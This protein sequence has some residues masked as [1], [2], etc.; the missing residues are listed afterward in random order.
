MKAIEKL[1]VVHS[2]KYHKRFFMLEF[3]EPY[4]YWY[5]GPGSEIS[6]NSHKQTDIIG[7]RILDDREVNDRMAE[8]ENKRS[9]SMLRRVLQDSV[10]KCAW[11]FAF[12][13]SFTDKE[14]E[15]YAPTRSD[16]DQWIHVLQTIAEM[17][18]TMIKTD[19]TS[20]FEWIKD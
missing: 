19:F 15:L 2:A 11:N 10:K 14:Y 17:N 13:L 9:K 3:G 12:I 18:K 1:S 4:C 16:R 7:C 8:R 6:H 5:E 20:P